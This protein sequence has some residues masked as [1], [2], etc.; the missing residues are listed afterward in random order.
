M[1]GIEQYLTKAANA[2]PVVGTRPAVG[3]VELEERLAEAL[4]QAERRFQEERRKAWR[5]MVH[6]GCE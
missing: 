3:A 1:T 4:N 5:R 6:F 2:V